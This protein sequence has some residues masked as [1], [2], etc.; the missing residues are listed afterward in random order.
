MLEVVWGQGLVL[1]G[2]DRVGGAGVQGV[3]TALSTPPHPSQLS[4]P[5]KRLKSL[6]AV[7]SVFFDRCGAVPTFVAPCYPL[8]CPLFLP[9]LTKAW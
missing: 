9:R 6:K 3:V 8:L 2:C 4:L 1:S 5:S 7:F